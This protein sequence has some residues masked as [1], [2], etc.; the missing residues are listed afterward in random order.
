MHNLINL[1]ILLRYIYKTE[2][3][4]LFTVVSK[5]SDLYKK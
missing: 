2:V 3:D 4:S 5:L 1:D